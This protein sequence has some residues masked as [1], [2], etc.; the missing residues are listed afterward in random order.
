VRYIRADHDLETKT[1]H[2]RS[3]QREAK[4]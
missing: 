1:I 4:I 2:L 3:M